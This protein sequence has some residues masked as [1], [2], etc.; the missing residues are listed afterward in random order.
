MS[1]AGSIEFELNKLI[2]FIM[3]IYLL[4]YFNNLMLQL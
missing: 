4:Y 3:K 2:W 1:E